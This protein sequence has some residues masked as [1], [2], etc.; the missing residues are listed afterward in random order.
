MNLHTVHAAGIILARHTDT[1]EP[2]FLLEQ[3]RAGHWVFPQG[4]REEGESLR[5]TARRELREETGVID[6]ELFAEPAFS[7]SYTY[8]HSGEQKQ[9]EV[10]LFLA[11]TKTAEVTPDTGELIQC[12]W[13][14]L[15]E[16]RE[17]LGADRARI[18]EEA[19][20]YFVDS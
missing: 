2:V 4:H 7:F 20:S 18:L 9:K 3:K 19:L 12:G 8:E 14:T 11:T 16:A 15:D 17:L 10:T 6:I 1:G 13:Y 5:D